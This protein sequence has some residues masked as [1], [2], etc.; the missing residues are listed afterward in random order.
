MTLLI[1][2]VALAAIG[3]FTAQ[4]FNK[5]PIIWAVI[6][7]LTGIFGL[8]FLVIKYSAEQASKNS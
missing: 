5:D 7:G 6:C 4:K 3:A 2:S 8:A 1:V